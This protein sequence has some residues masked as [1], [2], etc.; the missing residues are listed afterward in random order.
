MA[1]HGV[2]IVGQHDALSKV[3]SYHTRYNLD[4]GVPMFRLMFE[5]LPRVQI[6]GEG[7]DLGTPG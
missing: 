1:P 3:V 5:H 4:S 7:D 2:S 6:W